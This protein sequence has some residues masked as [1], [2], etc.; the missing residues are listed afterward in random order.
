MQYLSLSK[1]VANSR[2]SVE[3]AVIIIACCIPILQPLLDLCLGRG[4]SRAASKG[5]K[6]YGS[7]RDGSG[8]L[9]SN[10][11]EL[12]RKG[13]RYPK[14]GTDVSRIHGGDFDN[15]DD[16]LRTRAEVDSQ[17]SILHIE[18]NR[19]KKL[20]IQTEMA[21]DVQGGQQPLGKKD[22]SS[23]P[24]IVRTDVVSVSYSNG[25]KKGGKNWGAIGGI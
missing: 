4:R 23:G 21:V 24:G 15:V 9:R 20:P 16:D 17:E 14:G 18:T 19:D 8:H 7:S 13:G 10:D 12:E 5:Y 3:G 11:I 2:S 6:N 25:K 22:R 1:L